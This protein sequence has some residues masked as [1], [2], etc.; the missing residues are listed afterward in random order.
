M[1]GCVSTAPPAPPSYST[2]HLIVKFKPKIVSIVRGRA[3]P[4]GAA[5]AKIG[6]DRKKFKLENPRGGEKLEWRRWM[7]LTVPEETDPASL[8]PSLNRHPLIEYAELDYDVKTAPSP[9]PPAPPGL[10]PNDPEF[11][12]QSFHEQISSPRAWLISTGSKNVTVAVLDSGC[13]TELPEFNGRITGPLYD[14]ED[15]DTDVSDDLGHGTAICGI[16]GATGDNGLLVAGMDWNGKIMPL[17]VVRDGV[18]AWARAIEWAVE[19]GARVIN[20]SGR[21]RVGEPS[22]VLAEAF[23]LAHER[24]V[25]VVC[26]AGNDGLEEISYPAN[27]PGIIA[28]GAVNGKGRRWVKSETEGS[29]FGPGL[30][31]VAPGT[32]VLTTSRTGG[33]TAGQGT[34]ASAAIVSG[35]CSLM[36][37]VNPALSPKEIR[38]IL[39]RTADRL[40]PK[41]ERN[42]DGWHPEFGYGRVNAFKAVLGASG[43][44]LII[45]YPEE[46]ELS[47]GAAEPDLTAGVKAYAANGR[48]LDDYIK[49]EGTVNMSKTGRYAVTY[50]LE[51]GGSNT[52]SATRLY[53]VGN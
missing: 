15:D 43:R 7:L 42:A 29:N 30:D 26:S 31:L 2:E 53:K 51:D 38:A 36:L 12:R 3:D 19:H 6:L 49:T 37:A 44:P 41:A 23:A 17:K 8:T 39:T 33:I 24:G 45:V 48:R 52:S 32:H 27:L 14:F 16:I 9:P 20:I 50:T 4:Y 22:R 10:I 5:V 1:S 11:P 13:E 18:A 25:V 47:A 34:S 28:V 40:G 21:L 46:V 35:V